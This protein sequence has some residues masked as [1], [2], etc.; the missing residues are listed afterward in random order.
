LV[1][2]IRIRTLAFLA[3]LAVDQERDQEIEG[4]RAGTAEVRS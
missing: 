2:R 1:V 4:S 3:A